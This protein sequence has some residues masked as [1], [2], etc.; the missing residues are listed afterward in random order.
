ML[1]PSLTAIRTARST[2]QRAQE[3]F[4]PCIITISGVQISAAGSLGPLR[5]PFTEEGGGHQLVRTF[6]CSVS[7]S[8]LTTAPVPNITTL[9]H[10]GLTY[11]IR[12]IAGDET[13]LTAWRIVASR[14][15]RPS[16]V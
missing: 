5:R 16:E 6:T 14:T 12:E 7:K 11:T 3:E 8:L 4:N 1:L 13:H 2:L 10:E 9:I 15:A